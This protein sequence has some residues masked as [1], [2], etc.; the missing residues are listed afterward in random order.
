MG[1]NMQSKLMT[2]GEAANLVNS[3]DTVTVCGISGGI[4]PDKVMEALGSR[5]SETGQPGNLTM[6]LPIAVGDGYDI[7]GMEH[8]A[9]EGMLKQ[10][11]AGSYTVARSSQK[12]PKIYDMIINNRVAAYNVPI[13]TL[14]ELMREIAAK[15]PGIITE[16]GLGTFL[17]PRLEGGRMNEVTTED[18]VQVITFNDREYLFYPAFPI[19]VAII[20]GTS[21]DEYGNI[22]MEHE[23][24]L[25]GVLAMAMAA[26]NC[27]GKVIAQVKCLVARESLHP[28]M[29]RVPGILVDAIVIDENQ[30]LTTGIKNDFS[31]SGQTRQPWNSI[32]TPP[33]TGIRRAIINRVL[34]E[35][36][37]G[38]VINLGFGL[39]SSLPQAVLEE[40]II[41]QLV[42]TTEHGCIGGYPYDGIQFGGAINPQALID[43]PNQFDFLEGGGPD[44]VCLSFAEM[45]QKGNVNVTR[46]KQMPHVLAGAGGFSNIV[47]N[48]GTLIFCGTMTAGG[49]KYDI[50]DKGLKLVKPGKF[51]KVI[52]NV[53][54]VTFNGPQAYAKGQKVLYITDLCVFELTADGVAL[55]ETAPALDLEKDILPHIG[56]DVNIAPEVKTTDPAVYKDCMGLKKLAP[57]NEQKDN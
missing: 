15:R 32:K 30:K 34:L 19:D 43:V 7:M 40:G 36:K 27:G 48:A 56:F 12:P 51:K 42:F 33:L 39:T 11:I 54:Q 37:P 41:D 14:M 20:R 31:A 28:Q 35:L 4:T 2:A 26:R 9:I 25:S 18:V 6:V 22:T 44:V 45:D 49:V 16:V 57:W 46:L 47:Q 3:G 10:I 38:D 21:A 17:D 55:I 1:K 5:Y 53:Q 50:S 13:G 8:L 29:V 24:T 23:F 52:N